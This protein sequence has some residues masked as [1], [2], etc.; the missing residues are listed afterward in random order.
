MKFGGIKN[1]RGDVVELS[2]ATFSTLLHA[3]DRAVRRKAFHQY[4]REYAD[5]AHT[6]AASLAGSMQADIYYAKA[7]NYP[8]A[9]EAA[10]FPD[11]VP[12]TVYDNLIALGPSPPACACTATTTCGGGRCG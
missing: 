2:H 11:Q 3:P 12:V 10:L 6:L 8:G 5:H 7:R 4:Y 1:D 9:L